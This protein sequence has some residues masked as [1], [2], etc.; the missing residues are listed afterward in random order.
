MFWKV[1]SKIYGSNY[2]G[3]SIFLNIITKK[4]GLCV[5]VS[6]FG[7]NLQT[8]K[9]H[10]WWSSRYPQLFSILS[11]TTFLITFYTSNSLVQQRCTWEEKSFSFPYIVIKIPPFSFLCFCAYQPQRGETLSDCPGTFVTLKG[12]CGT[13]TTLSDFTFIYLGSTAWTYLQPHYGNGVFSNERIYNPITAM[14][15]SAMFTF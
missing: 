12:A 8:N 7:T 4:W 14:G 9:W 5:F 11:A 15:F 10:H 13:T 2:Y 1:P 3:L 6:I